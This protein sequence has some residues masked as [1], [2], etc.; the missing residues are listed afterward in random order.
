M[1]L[2]RKKNRISHWIFVE[3]LINAASV[4]VTSLASQFESP[5]EIAPGLSANRK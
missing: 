4:E 3:R 5:R 1:T 2:N